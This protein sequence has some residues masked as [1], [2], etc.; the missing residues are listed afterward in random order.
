M[1]GFDIDD[2]KRKEELTIIKINKKDYFFVR[3]RLIDI[4]GFADQEKITYGLGY[5]LILK[6][7][8]NNDAILR[9]GGMI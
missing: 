4:F 5:Q 1:Y 2:T 6:R 7:N 3:I 8:T 9:A